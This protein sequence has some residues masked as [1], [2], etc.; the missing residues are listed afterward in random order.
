MLDRYYTETFNLLNSANEELCK[1]T[2]LNYKKKLYFIV[3]SYS[4]NNYVVLSYDNK[5]FFIQSAG[6]LG[7]KGRKRRYLFTLKMLIK[8][9]IKKLN[10]FY[11]NY[12][13]DTSNL[14]L[15]ELHILSGSRKVQ[16]L[17]NMFIT[18]FLKY[19][20]KIYMKQCIDFINTRNEVYLDRC[21]NSVI[22]FNNNKVS[23]LDI[24]LN[25][26]L[27]EDIYLEHQHNSMNELNKVNDLNVVD[28]GNEINNLNKV[29]KVN[30][31]N[32]DD[33][34]KNVYDNN[35]MVTYNEWI[36]RLFL[37]ILKYDKNLESNLKIQNNKFKR[38]NNNVLDILNSNKLLHFFYSVYKNKNID[39][40]I[41]QHKEK[42]SSKKENIDSLYLISVYVF[43]YME[44]LRDYIKKK[45]KENEFNE[46]NEKKK[47][48]LEEK[49]IEN[50]DQL[51]LSEEEL[52]EK[53]FKVLSLYKIF[54]KSRVSFGQG[55]KKIRLDNK[56]W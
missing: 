15:M 50:N 10:L 17:L 2:Q 41:R 26:E 11:S 45:K 25:K 34:I 23:T 19:K 55:I 38:M 12:I 3:N 36:S 49:V 46:E 5:P 33:E 31:A 22:Q 18:L 48:E 7:F 56:Y 52:L 24:Y 6:L 14:L 21:I 16:K 30:E 53:E 37:F 51:E 20:K 40:L 32:G 47:L 9:A 29:D 35:S 1:E 8:N 44:L 4:V 28:N 54:L 42:L 27:E 43:F 13:N 39:V